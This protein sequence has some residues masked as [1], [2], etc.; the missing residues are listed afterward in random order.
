MASELK[1]DKRFNLACKEEQH[2]TDASVKSV[3]DNGMTE[4]TIGRELQWMFL[5]P[6]RPFKNQHNQHEQHGR[7][8]NRQTWHGEQ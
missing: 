6:R 1:I 2:Q 8:L 4:E 3:T 5:L 7:F